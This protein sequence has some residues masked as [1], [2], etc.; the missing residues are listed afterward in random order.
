MDAFL[1]SIIMEATVTVMRRHTTK[2]SMRNHMH[3]MRHIPSITMFESDESEI[4]PWKVLVYVIIMTGNYSHV[5]LLFTK[6]ETIPRIK[7]ESTYLTV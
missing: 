7:A 1:S 2:L 6:E 5:F 3:T 4:I